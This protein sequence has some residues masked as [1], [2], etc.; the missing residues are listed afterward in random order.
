MAAAGPSS[1]SSGQQQPVILL[2]VMDTIVSD[3]FF[4]HMPRFFN[5]TF[6]VRHLAATP[7]PLSL[8]LLLWCDRAVS[9][10]KPLC[11]STTT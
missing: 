3:P 11:L 8:L 10:T 4:E 1:A 5:L 6:K 2:D 7:L 9:N